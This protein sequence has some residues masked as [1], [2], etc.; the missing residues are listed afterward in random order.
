MPSSLNP[1]HVCRQAARRGQR[2][3]QAVRDLIL[4]RGGPALQATQG[5]QR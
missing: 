2:G 1:A 3:D 4:E 5:T